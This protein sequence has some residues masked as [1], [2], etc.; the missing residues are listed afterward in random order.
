MSGFSQNSLQR[1]ISGL[2][3]SITAAISA[4]LFFTLRKLFDV[5]FNLTSGV[6]L[7]AIFQFIR[8]TGIQCVQ[9]VS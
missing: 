3:S 5:H 9:C 1:L 6:I 7:S 4:F 8:I 2:C